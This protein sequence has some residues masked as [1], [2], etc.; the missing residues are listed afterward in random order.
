MSEV[1]L[2][3]KEAF[4]LAC[5]ILENHDTARENACCVSRALVAAECAGQTGH[6]LSRLPSYSAQS[7]SGKVDGQAKPVIVD[8]TSAGIRIDAANGFAFPACAL[9]VRQLGTLARDTGIAAAA[10]FRS[11]H[12]GQAGYHVEMLADEGLVGLAFGN[13][14]KAIAPWGGRHAVFGTNPLAFAAPRPGHAPLVVDFGLGKAARGK[15]MLAAE[16]EEPIP[17]GWA[18]DDAGR[19]TT[20]ARAALAGTL[21]PMGGAK[22]AALALV[23][24][25]LSAILTGAQ[26]GHEASSFFSPEG[27]PP[28]VGQFL[29]AVDAAFFSGQTF[30]P[31]LDSLLTAILDQEGV[32][33]PGTRRLEARRQAAA[34]GLR[35][36]DT[37]YQ[38][39][40]M[41]A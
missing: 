7:A 2:F 8:R 39:L 4:R 16:N 31:R 28:G 29:I 3:P 40:K 21:L 17:E 26:C 41:L 25:V 18:L 11:H 23:V 30:G 35:I 14:P 9:A 13:S 10:I 12:F 19:P 20:D 27:R 37:L 15:V 6:G 22:G 36:P 38:K 5:Q 33:L 1:R 24:E 34:H 32:R